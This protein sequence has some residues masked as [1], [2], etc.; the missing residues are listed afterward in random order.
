MKKTSKIKVTPID[1]RQKGIAKLL[2]KYFSVAEPNQIEKIRFSIFNP[3]KE[4]EGRKIACGQYRGTI[5]FLKRI[6]KDLVTERNKVALKDGYKNHLDFALNSDGVPKRRFKE[7]LDESDRIIK[8]INRNLPLLREVPEWYWSEFNIPDALDQFHSK[9]YKIPEDVYELA[10]K[11]WPE[12]KKY[13]SKI[14]IRKMRDFFP[15]TKFEKEDKSVFIGIPPKRNIYNLLTFVHE[16]GH[17]IGMLRRLE[18]G[19]NLVGVTRYQMEKEAYEFKFAFEEKCLPKEVKNAS[20]GAILGDFLTAFFEYEIYTN[21]DRD[22]DEVYAKAKNRCFPRADQER[23]PFYVLD[24]VLT[25]SPCSVVT[26]SVVQAELLL[27]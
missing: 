2:G 19:E 9:R 21:P 8:D 1:K 11:E 15:R 26:A 6:F 3:A 27:K 20:R 12:F 16:L 17:A 5:L 13:F 10:G 23:N 22:F 24:N 7:F 18:F 25:L 14:K 4:L